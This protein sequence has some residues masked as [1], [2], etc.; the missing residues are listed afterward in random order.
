MVFGYNAVSRPL[1]PREIASAPFVT[2]SV[3]MRN[4]NDINAILNSNLPETRSMPWHRNVG[5]GILF[6]ASLRANRR[7]P[8]RQ[9]AKIP[10]RG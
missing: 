6:S 9:D 4:K 8:L 7:I 5:S 2:R 3:S 1:P 10:S